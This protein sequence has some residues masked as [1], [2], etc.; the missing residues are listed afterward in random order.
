MIYICNNYNINTY[1]IFDFTKK[2]M[3]ENN[4][5]ITPEDCFFVKCIIDNNIGIIPSFD[6]AKYFSSESI[7]CLDS[8][9]GHCFWL[10]NKNWINRFDII[11]KK[12]SN[13]GIKYIKQYNHRYGWNNLLMILY[14]NDIISPHN[15]DTNI[16]LIDLC[17][18]YFIWDNNTINKKWIGIIHLTPSSPKYL[19][20]LNINKLLNHNNFK[21][22]LKHCVKLITLSDYLKTY[23]NNNFEN[24]KNIIDIVKIYHPI[25]NVNKF[26]S[27]E[28]Y[29][30]NNNKYILQIGQQLRILK[31]FLNINIK[32]HK[33][34]WICNN[35]TMI[36]NNLNKELNLNLKSYDDFI[37]YLELYDIIHKVLNN[38][39]YDEL[40]TKNIIFIHL[41]D[42]SANNTLLEAI[43]HKIPIIINKHPAIVE[44]L[45]NDYPLY[46]N[47]ISE[48]NNNFINDDIIIK[49]YNYLNNYKNS[50]IMY[51]NFCAHLLDNMK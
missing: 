38:K 51:K 9:G 33:K 46:Y 50:N 26:F 18:N 49:A 27:L 34:I 7:N 41:Y 21:E 14:I 36:I 2:Y 48:L 15:I 5:L 24:I 16:E 20:N 31:T 1:E 13:I 30:K 28:N 23:I 25:K 17:E 19:N 10:N 6:D 45:G 39:D 43:I 4:L 32:S 42:A 44:Y 40:I 29:L 3:K 35:N 22:S 8:L 11:I 47:N 12:F 37:N